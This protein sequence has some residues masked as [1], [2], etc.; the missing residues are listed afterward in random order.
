MAKKKDGNP[1]EI[2]VK[3]IKKRIQGNEELIKYLD[4]ERANMKGLPDPS[5][6]LSQAGNNLYHAAQNLKLFN[7]NMK[8][9]I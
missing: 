8:A 4:K 9:H 2:A 5:G 6:H 1:K 3:Q 7:N